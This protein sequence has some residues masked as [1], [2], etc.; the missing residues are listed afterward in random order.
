MNDLVLSNIDGTGMLSVLRK[1]T[2][3]LPSKK[4]A[5]LDC[6]KLTPAMTWERQV[7]RVPTHIGQKF[8]N[9]GSGRAF[10]SSSQHPQCDFGHLMTPRLISQG[11]TQPQ[12][13][14]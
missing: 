14:I 5:L 4:Q 7:R 1:C 11:Q 8:R 6:A 12:H 13:N 3:R 2:K 10:I 9:F